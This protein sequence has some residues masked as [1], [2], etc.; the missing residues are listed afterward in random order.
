MSTTR[1]DLREVRREA[2]RRRLVAVT[3]FGRSAT[4]ARFALAD[5]VEALQECLACLNRRDDDQ[6]AAAA[7]WIRLAGQQVDKAL[8]AIEHAAGANAKWVPRWPAP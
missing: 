1:D 2:E 5:A 8:T 6:A 4:K 7:E 3:P